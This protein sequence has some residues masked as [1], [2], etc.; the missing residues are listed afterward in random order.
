MR[1]PCLPWSSLLVASSA[2]LFTAC[3]TNAT[4]SGSGG[5]GGHAEASSSTGDLGGGGA[6]GAPRDHGAPSDVY[7]AFHPSVP[8]IV[9]LSGSVLAQPKLVPVFFD[10]DDAAIT[11]HTDAFASALGASSYWAANTAEYGV[12]PIAYVSSVHLSETPSAQLDDTDI[13]A[14][15]RGKLQSGDPAFPKPDGSTIYMITYPK[16]VQI[17]EGGGTACKQFGAY[18]NSLTL[19]AA[20][21]N[22]VVP[23]AVLPRCTSFQ[24]LSGADMVTAG[25]SHELVE[26]VTDPQPYADPAFE[27]LDDDHVF[28][29]FALG[30]ETGDMCSSG[31]SAYFKP[32]GLDYTVQRCWSNQAASLLHDPCVPKLGTI[33]YFNTA[34]VLPDVH[35]TLLFGPK[36]DSHVV[37]IGVGETRAVEL[38]LFS[39]EKTNGPWKVEVLDF[40]SLYGGPKKLAISLDRTSGRNGEKIWADITALEK[41]SP[42]YGGVSLFLIRSSLGAMRSTWVGAVANQ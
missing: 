6:G 40:S 15:L 27:M 29:M 24:G 16:G 7:P 26:T 20:H 12:G 31:A 10:G 33:A 2:W 30:A 41:A 9:K 14:W 21:G 37:T 28:W 17:T 13:Q 42:E 38:D 18:H 5:A 4:P 11:A 1:V 25:A 23:F 34:A 19:D 22:V 35:S 39:D 3:T 8:S 32:D 36:I